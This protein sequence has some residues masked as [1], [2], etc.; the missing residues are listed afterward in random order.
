[1][2]HTTGYGNTWGVSCPECKCDKHQGELVY[3]MGGNIRRNTRKFNPRVLGGAGTLYNQNT[4]GNW[5]G[6][7]MAEGCLG[8]DCPCDGGWS[9]ACDCSHGGVHCPN[10]KCA[11]AQGKIMHSSEFRSGGRVPR[12][13]GRRFQQ[14]GG[15]GPCSGLDGYGNNC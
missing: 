4:G 7:L 6:N 2:S 11:T 3:D 5:G 9:A 15:T 1:M 12:R 13:R 10:C 14:G 8:L